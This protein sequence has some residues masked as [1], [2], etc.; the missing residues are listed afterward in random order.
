[1]YNPLSYTQS[2]RASSVSFGHTF[3]NIGLSISASANLTQNMRDSTIALTL[4]DVSISLARFYPFRRKHQAGKERWYEKISMSYT[5]Q[6]S[7]SITTKEN[8]LFKSNL[9]KDW[10]NG[11]QHR[12]PIDATFQLFKYINISPSFSFRDIMYASRINRSWNT[13][14]Q[15]E[16]CDTTYGFYNLYDWNV[17]VTANTTLY[18][19]TNRGKSSLVE[20]LWPFATCSSPL[21]PLA[22]RPTLPPRAMAT[23]RSMSASMPRA[24][25]PWWRIRP[26]Q[27]AYMVTPRGR[28]RA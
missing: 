14:L 20:R 16:V 23:A 25:Q 11:M 12:V 10:R 9:I 18:G 5:G 26:T 1:M 4:P 6:M 8:L 13:L 21:S 28:S 19:F 22:M 15:Q 3:T 24:I 27:T 7:N 17:G 2:T